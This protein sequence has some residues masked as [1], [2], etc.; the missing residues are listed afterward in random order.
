MRGGSRWL[1]RLVLACLPFFP[2]PADAQE[3]YSEQQVKAA[4]LY[5]FLGFVEWPAEAFVEASA[6]IVVSVVGEPALAAILQDIVRGRTVNGHPVS[7]RAVH[8][9]EPIEGSHVVFVSADAGAA[10]GS[11]LK[12][13]A[14]L[15]I[16]TITDT[17]DGLERGSMINF[18]TH[19][20]N[21]RFEVALDTVE[22]A[23]LRLSSRLLGV[24][25]RV[26]RGPPR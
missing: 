8:A 25:V 3:T 6:P 18:V 17:P 7:V 19:E 11:M 22:R 10:A 23:G 15:G 4:F 20:R 12:H 26:R 24:A 14:E 2:L 16:L 21:V 9:R 13:A 1:A 5:R